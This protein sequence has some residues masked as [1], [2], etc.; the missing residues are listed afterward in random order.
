MKLLLPLFFLYTFLSQ[1]TE[2]EMLTFPKVNTLHEAVF[3][4][5]IEKV[6][7]LIKRGVDV[8][9]V[10]G[11]RI[12][13]GT[14]VVSFN[15]T[16][17][18]QKNLTTIKERRA[19]LKNTLLTNWLKNYNDNNSL[20]TNEGTTPLHWIRN[21]NVEIA[22]LLIE[23]GA[24]VNAKTKQESWT[25]F[26]K[27]VNSPT[28]IIPAQ[29]TPLHVAVLNKNIKTAKLLIKNR[30]YINIKNDRG[31]TS[32]YYA[33]S[34]KMIKLLIDNGADVNVR[35]NHGNSPLYYIGNPPV[36]YT[37]DSHTLIYRFQMEQLL[38]DNGADVNITN[39]Y[40]TNL[41]EK[42][43]W[44]F[45]KIHFLMKNGATGKYCKHRY[46]R[47]YIGN[48]FTKLFCFFKTCVECDDFYCDD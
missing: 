28:V 22:K 30:A 47:I 6:K 4:G 9:N 14:S 3:F 41:C 48:I 10:S 27:V 12:I 5:D 13:Q 11:E 16:R 42:Y 25:K 23:N 26:G 18:G 31:Y 29:S 2:P 33:K 38:I 17:T 8:N 1:A 19:R 7:D 40:G 34:F 24:D 44:Y 45:R 21:D 36:Y 32:L 35:D 15:F 43:R 46:F 39:N 37:K 20:K